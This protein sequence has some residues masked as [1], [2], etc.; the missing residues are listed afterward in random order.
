MLLLH[1]MVQ[2]K[3][4]EWQFVSPTWWKLA[5]SVCL[6]FKTPLWFDMLLPWLWK[7]PPP[8]ATWVKIIF[9]FS[10][11]C[12]FLKNAICNQLL[13]IWKPSGPCLLLMV[14]DCDGCSVSWADKILCTEAKVCTMSILVLLFCTQHIVKQLGTS[15][16]SCFTMGTLQVKN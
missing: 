3:R 12:F 5:C 10:S 11:S 4:L 8:K 13:R 1:N 2:F 7:Q 14:Q 15:V 9:F 6:F 16:K